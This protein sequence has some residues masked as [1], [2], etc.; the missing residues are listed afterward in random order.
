MNKKSLIVV[1]GLLL[2]SGTSTFAQKAKIRE[3][4][5]HFETAT[6]QVIVV[7]ATNSGPT[8]F[9]DKSIVDPLLKAKAAIEAA[10][11]NEETANNADAWFAKG[12]IFVEMARIPDFKKERHYVEGFQAFEKAYALNPKV[13]SKEGIET[14]LFNVGIFGLN[15]ISEE[16]A[17][18]DYDKMI[19]TADV[20]HKAL[21]MGDGKLFKNNKATV[22]TL[23]ATAEYYKG[24]GYYL[25][26]DYTK[27]IEILEKNLKAPAAQSNS[28][29]YRILAFAYGETKNTEKQL[30]TIENA[31]AKFPGNK[32]IEI[33]ELNYYI[34]QNKQG[35]L[36]G[37]FEALVAKEPNNAQYVHNL[38]V[39]YRNMGM[40]KDGAFPADAASW[41]DKAEAQLKKAVSLEPNNVPFNFNLSNLYVVKADLVGSQMNKLGNTKAD[42]AKYDE[43]LKVRTGLLQQG[44]A[45][46]LVV[47]KVLDPKIKS[48]KITNDE[49]GYL[50]ESLQT[51]GRLYGAVDDAASSKKYKEKLRNYEDGIFN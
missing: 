20:A 35:E 46:L 34:A 16:L 25:K 11:T 43:L 18:E 51:L 6:E 26:K 30:Q 3:A 10:T 15:N 13:L 24:F 22:D 36:V 44:I 12:Q 27:A 21:T 42:N 49:R 1:C 28:D 31:K 23:S 38:G 45:P 17:N 47:E 41:H 40:E 48:G 33:D 14:A 37:R 4:N 39:L 9:N 8:A 19:Q 7:S 32:D 2:A 50:L 5:R 29:A